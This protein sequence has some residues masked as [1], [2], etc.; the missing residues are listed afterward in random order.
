MN[1][2]RGVSPWRAL[3]WH[4]EVKGT[5]KVKPRAS[6]EVP[7]GCLVSRTPPSCRLFE[8]I[9]RLELEDVAGLNHCTALVC[10]V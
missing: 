8:Q 2:I 7:S 6:C 3:L 1:S 5:T 9:A 4:V 10:F